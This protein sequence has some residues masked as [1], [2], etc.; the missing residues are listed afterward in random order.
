MT[1]F[2]EENFEKR[3]AKLF[4]IKLKLRLGVFL[5][6][7]PLHSFRADEPTGKLTKPSSSNTTN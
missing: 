6:R 5:K 1:L 7:A 4:E 2:G 3:N